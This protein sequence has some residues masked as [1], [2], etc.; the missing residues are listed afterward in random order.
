MLYI[1]ECKSIET[2]SLTAWQLSVWMWR[3]LRSSSTGIGWGLVCYWRVF[4][5][6]VGGVYTYCRK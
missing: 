5:V 1:P 3:G 4:V 2:V 6:G